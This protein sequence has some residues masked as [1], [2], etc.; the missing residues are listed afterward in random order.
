[1]ESQEMVKRIEG[2]LKA[3]RIT[4]GEFYK[5]CGVTAAAMSNWRRGL[6]YPAIDTIKTIEE[7]LGIDL[8]A[9][10]NPASDDTGVPSEFAAIYS[11]LSA[12][13]RADLDKFARF[14]LSQEGG[15]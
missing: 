4:K 10:E 1:M 13:G 14:L 9:K 7:Y 11:R 3:K 6:N 8:W 5:A 12:Q 15:K 2:A